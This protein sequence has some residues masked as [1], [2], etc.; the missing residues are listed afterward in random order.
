MLIKTSIWIQQTNIFLYY[1]LKK[2]EIE[3]K[4][5]LYKCQNRRGVDT[6]AVLILLKKKINNKKTQKTHIGPT[7]SPT[8]VAL[9]LEC[10]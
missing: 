6:I 5:V 4:N 2:V 3:K 8:P 10:G 7:P 9:E 1:T